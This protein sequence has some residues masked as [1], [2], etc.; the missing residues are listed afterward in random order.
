MAE[1]NAPKEFPFPSD[2]ESADYRLFPDD[3]E[4][5]ALVFFHGTAESK[6]QSIL[7]NGFRISGPLPSVSFGRNSSLCLGYACN[8]RGGLSPKGVV[9][10]VRFW[11]LGGPHIVQESFGLHVYD[12][13]NPPQIIG[14]CVVPES[15]THQ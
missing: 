6:L 10:A 12:L 2:P 4:S 11:R 3:L 9:I 15:Y 8:A 7:E 1:E 13:S 14:Y 5:D